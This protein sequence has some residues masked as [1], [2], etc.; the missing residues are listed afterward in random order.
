MHQPIAEGLEEY[1]AGS[2]SPAQLAEIERHL[3]ACRSCSA[4]LAVLREHQAL[5]M[6]LRAP[7]AIDPAPGFY[8]RVIGRIEAQRTTSFWSILLEPAIG[9]RLLYASLA[10][11]LVMGAAIWRSD[12]PALLDDANPMTIM[13]ASDLPVA[14]GED[15]GQA[16]A[17]VLT[18]LVGLSDAGAG[19]R[20]L[21]VSS[22]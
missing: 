7:E 14:A 8:G 2:A 20:A 11:S 22:D 4:E 3:A 13:A 17:V 12:G 18:H 9:R 1:L 16:R 15:P 5:L 19:P 21:P 10:L 6:G